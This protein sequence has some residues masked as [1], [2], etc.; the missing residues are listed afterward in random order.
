MNSLET[1]PPRLSIECRNQLRHQWLM[2]L[3]FLAL[4][5]V[6]GAQAYMPPLPPPLSLLGIYSFPLGQSPQAGLLLGTNGNYYVTTSSSGANNYG[7]IYE[8]TPQGFLSNSFLF[9]GANGAAPFAPLIQGGD[10]YLYGTTSAGGISNNGT[11]FKI[12]PA[13]NSNS[14]VTLVRFN[15]TNGAQPYAPLLKATNGLFYGTTSSGGTNDYGTIFVMNSAGM[16]T[17]LY[18]F[19]WTTGANPYAGLVQ[20]KDGNLYGATRYGGT[21]GQGTIF[22]ISPAGNFTNLVSFYGANGSDPRGLVQG[23]DSNFYGVTFSGGFNDLGTLF[24]MTPSGSFIMRSLSVPDGTNPDGPLFHAADG[25]F[26]GA[27][28]QGGTYGMGAVLRFVTGSSAAN[29]TRFAFPLGWISFDGI[30]GAYP[31]GGLIQDANGNLLGATSYGGDNGSGTI[32]ELTGFVPVITQPPASQPFASHSTAKFLVAAS[33]SAPLA[34]QWL[35][36]GTILPGATT[37]NLTITN[38]TAADVGTYSIIVSNPY[39][40]ATNSAQLTVSAPAITVKP[41]PPSG[42]TAATLTVSGSA[43]DTSIQVTNVQYQS[44]AN[45]ANATT[46]N[47]WTNWSASLSLQPGSNL[48]QVW[49]VDQLGNTSPTNSYPIFY[50]VTNALALYTNGPGKITTPAGFNASQLILGKTY[51]LTAVPT[52]G[53]LFSNWTGSITSPAPTLGFLMAP[54]LTLTANFVTNVFKGAKGVYNG[55]FYDSEDTNAITPATAGLLSALTVNSNGSYTGK[56]LLAGS[57]F[58]ISGAFDVAVPAT[59]TITRTTNNGGPVTLAIYLD[60]SNTPPAVLGTVSAL[61]TNSPQWTAQLMADRQT[62]N[63][64]SAACTLLLPPGPNPSGG[65]PGTGYAL[66]TNHQGT[67][68]I[69]GALADGTAFTQTVPASDQGALPLYASLYGG[70]GLLLGWITNLDNGAPAG[71]LAWIKTPTPAGLYASGFTNTLS[72]Q[73]SLWTNPPAHTA[74]ISLSGG[75]LSVSN[76]FLAA[77]L[78]YIVSVN[79]SNAL[80]KSSSLPTNSLTGSIN[81][82]TGL[83]QLSFGNGHGKATTAA[84]G[85]ILQNQ[86]SGAGFFTTQTNAGSITLQP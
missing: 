46:T 51:T 32:F 86:S 61:G 82:K 62:T 58:S 3:G 57:T 38:E 75:T 74:A 26:Y 77:P 52:N 43:N 45:L 22:V 36:N 79:T 21:N 83:L 35:L 6:A 15:N 44:G 70:T 41:L 9:G 80:A 78:I 31:S 28:L 40:A 69:V 27:A 49:S 63:L 53:N 5:F 14:I 66:I 1:I 16:F 29:P 24:Q 67:A 47:Q 30:N 20:G 19:D 48:F 42:T 18:S 84:Q 56:V 68:T 85:A 33:G 7:A 8:V 39:G 50:Y 23:S 2:A 65:P 76:G 71:G 11:I 17:N 64:A 54:N 12:S 37:T 10:G 25:A 4:A 72:V 13:L 60:L 73:G 81:P 59:N 55:L 34:Y